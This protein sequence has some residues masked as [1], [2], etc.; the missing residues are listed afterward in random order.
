MRL[1]ADAQRPAIWHSRLV[2][3]D[4]YPVTIVRAR[5]GGIYEPGEWLAFPRDPEK[6][7][8]GWQDEDV[9]C[10]EFWELW[11]EPVGSGATP[12]DAYTDLLAKGR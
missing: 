8:E 2:T 12:T 10:R 6:L 11:T 5:Y 1:I 4:V 7:P 3:K 9:P